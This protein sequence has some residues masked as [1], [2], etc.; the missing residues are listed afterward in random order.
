MTSHNHNWKCHI[1]ELRTTPIIIRAKP[2][3][4]EFVEEIIER[5]LTLSQTSYLMI[6]ICITLQNTPDW[7]PFE[8]I[9]FGFHNNIVLQTVL[10]I[11][12]KHVS[13]VT[14]SK[15]NDVLSSYF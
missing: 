2:D 6:E 3:Y 8:T 11:L 9:K 5:K 4:A 10:R 7:K 13:E 15:F 12:Q 1:S 14:Y